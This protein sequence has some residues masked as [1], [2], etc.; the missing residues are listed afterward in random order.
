MKPLASSLTA[1]ALIATASAADWPQF[2]GPGGLGV[3]ADSAE[4]PSEFGPEKNV[5]WQVPL[6][7]G[8]S[9]PV[10]WG[11][12]IFLTTFDAGKLSAVCLDRANGRTLWSRDIPAE[13]IEQVHRIGSPAAATPCRMAS[14]C[15]FTSA[16][17]G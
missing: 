13:K 6:A 11:D 2:R 9:S 3:A 14:A 7:S 1:L 5:V 12:R 16:R 8:H 15:I 17:S 10:L 4:V